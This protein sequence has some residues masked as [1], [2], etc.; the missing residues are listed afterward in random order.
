[1]ASNFILNNYTTYRDQQLKGWGLVRGFLSFCLVCGIGA[2]ANVGI[3][4][5]LFNNR[6][7]WVL[8]ALAGVIVGAVWNYAVTAAYTWKA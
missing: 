7:E 3:A 5:Y 1:M 6:T 8:S 4:A 2:V